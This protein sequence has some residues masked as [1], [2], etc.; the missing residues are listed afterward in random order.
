MHR[1]WGCLRYSL[2]WC[3]C[4]APEARSPATCSETQRKAQNDDAADGET[5]QKQTAW[6]PLRRGT[7]DGGGAAPQEPQEM[8]EGLIYLEK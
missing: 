7:S 5:V 8:M 2:S 6:L 4:G 1:C 3:L